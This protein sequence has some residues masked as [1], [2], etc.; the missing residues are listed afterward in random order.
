V[1]ALL[2]AW[3]IS[4]PL[5]RPGVLQTFVNSAWTLS[6][7]RLAGLGSMPSPFHLRLSAPREN[8]PPAGG[9]SR[10]GLRREAEEV[11]L[12]I[13]G[14]SLPTRLGPVLR[15]RSGPAACGC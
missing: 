9:V 3:F 8:D 5:G 10:E 7:R 13:A 6:Y 15:L 14:A 4:G 1:A 12:V 11:A 2:A